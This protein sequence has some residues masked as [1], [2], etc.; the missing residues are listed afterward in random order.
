ME[1]LV[2]ELRIRLRA[3]PGKPFPLP[4]GLT[5]K[6]SAVL[7]PF[8][9]RGGVPH[10]LFTKRPSHLRRHAGQISFP[11]GAR[12][13]EDATPLATALREAREELDIP[14][15]SVDVLGTLD[16]IPTPTEFRVQPYVGALPSDVVVR[17][18]VDEV[19]VVLEVPL[20]HLLRPNAYRTERL[21]F[22]GREYDIYFFDYGA[23]TIWGA[24]AHI[25]R[26]L[27]DV[28]GDLPAWKAWSTT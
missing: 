7:V 26:N 3:R 13:A 24:T 22:Q 23:H 5:L 25:L 16:E 19:E 1:A 21:P 17:P 14:P 15:A 18:S 20:P 8:V 6:E 11:G 4:P 10:I 28:A 12:D 9:A 2:E 27:M